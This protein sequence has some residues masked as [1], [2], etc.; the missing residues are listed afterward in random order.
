MSWMMTKLSDISR[1][2]LYFCRSFAEQFIEVFQQMTNLQLELVDTKD[3]QKNTFDGVSIYML[4]SGVFH[5]KLQLNMEL[6]Q[7]ESSCAQVY[8]GQL[9]QLEDRLDLMKEVLNI[10]S[11]TVLI[12]FQEAFG[13][14]QIFPPTVVIGHI[15]YPRYQ[16]FSSLV[17]GACGKIECSCMLNMVESSIARILARTKRKL[18]EREAEA[19]MDPLTGLYNRRHFDFHLECLFASAQALPGQE[20]YLAMVDL[21]HFKSVNDQW[22]HDMGDLALQAVARNIRK[23]TSESLMGFRTGGDEFCLVFEGADQEHVLH[24]CN[25]LCSEVQAR[26]F[27]DLDLP[28][29]HELYITVSIGLA[30]YEPEMSVAGLIRKADRGLY[31]SKDR[32]RACVTLV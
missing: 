8:G 5:G 3:L 1:F 13:E 27:A 32:G 19:I 17:T 14:H 22:G 21:D 16:T 29:G 23:M 18:S 31:R 20:I 6:A 25:Q 10:A 9:N 24:V 7:L 2:G 4:F 11:Q 26:P 15:E 12:D 30:C 28:E